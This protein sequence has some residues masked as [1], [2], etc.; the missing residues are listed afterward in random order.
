M[1]AETQPQ[2][3]TAPP[4]IDG[5]RL[6]EFVYGTVTG[7]VAIAGVGVSDDITWLDMMAIIITGALAIWLAHA[8]SNLLSKRVVS[9]HR[10]LHSEILEIL[11]SSWTI[12]IAGAVLSLPFPGVGIGLWSFGSALAIASWVGVVILALVGLV[13]GIITKER[14]PRRLLLAALSAGLGLAIVAI[15]FAVHH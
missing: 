11:S 14:W 8:Y 3:T 5:H 1:T 4:R 9:G 13:A 15:E 6:S 2:N 10:L 12:V 7:M